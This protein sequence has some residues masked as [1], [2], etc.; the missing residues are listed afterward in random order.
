MKLSINSRHKFNGFVLLAQTLS[1]YLYCSLSFSYR[2]GHQTFCGGTGPLEKAAQDKL[3]LKDGVHPP[4]SHSLEMPDEF[5][6]A[7]FPLFLAPE[8]MTYVRAQGIIEHNEEHTAV[9]IT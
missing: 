4:I 9:E 1:Q 5:E 7:Q 6:H 2:L 8:L 3:G